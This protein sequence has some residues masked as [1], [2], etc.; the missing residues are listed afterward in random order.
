MNARY[1]FKHF[2]QIVDGLVSTSAENG[3]DLDI[4]ERAF[5][6][7]VFESKRSVVNARWVTSNSNRVL[8]AAAMTYWLSKIAPISRSELNSNSFIYIN[9]L[10]SVIFGISML[11]I[12]FS[13]L[14]KE[15]RRNLLYQMSR[16][17][18]SFY[19]F[20]L[21]YQM[22]SDWKLEQKQTQ[23]QTLIAIRSLGRCL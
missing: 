11:D 5:A 14:K 8:F 18:I 15:F 21:L 19:A 22:L 1:L 10:A 12:D 7:A 23:E 4:S 2:V 16:G 9:D 20:A 3:D 6:L 17:E 13:S